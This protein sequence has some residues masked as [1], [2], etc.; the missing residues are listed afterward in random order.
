MNCLILNKIMRIKGYK[1][2][3]NNRLL[4]RNQNLIKSEIKSGR[5]GH[6]SFGSY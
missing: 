1:I 4:L 6:S 3:C 5:F 2:N